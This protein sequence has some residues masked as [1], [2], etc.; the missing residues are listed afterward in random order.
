MKFWDKRSIC[1]LLIIVNLCFIWGNSLLPAEQSQ[2]LS[3]WV[4]EMLPE[5]TEDAPGG[6]ENMI[7]RKLAHFAE[8]AVLGLL[9]SWLFRMLR[10]QFWYPLLLGIGAACV[11]ETIQCFV[12]GRGPGIVDVAIDACGILTGMLLVQIGYFLWKQNQSKQDGGY[13]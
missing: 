10:K 7:L 1:I 4:L 13:A 6:E 11:D 9:L 5:L 3:D 8:F 2:A 12:P